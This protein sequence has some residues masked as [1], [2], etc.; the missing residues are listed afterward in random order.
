MSAETL[1]ALWRNRGRIDAAFRRDPA[2]RAV[3]L[4]HAG[5]RGT[6]SGVA[7]VALQ[8][9]QREFGTQAR[10]VRVGIGPG[11]CGRCY[12]VGPEVAD[13]FDGRFVKRGEGDRFLLDLAAANRALLEGAGVTAVHDIAMCTKESYLFPSHRRHP[14]G[15]RFGA[16]VAVR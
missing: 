3:G 16:I 7:V 4:A 11:I 2:N 5:W 8:A 6:R 9:M 13:E 10:D 1:R 14:D 12:E 15:T